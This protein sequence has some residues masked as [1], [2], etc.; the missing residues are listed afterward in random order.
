M[1]SV[2]VSD[3]DVKKLCRRLVRLKDLSHEEKSLLWA[4]FTIAAD[5][6]NPV[7]GLGHT[8]LVEAGDD[9]ELT[10]ELLGDASAFLNDF[11]GR[12]VPDRVAAAFAPGAMPLLADGTAPPVRDLKVTDGMSLKVR[13]PAT[14]KPSR[15]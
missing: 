4:V 3:A 11:D 13:A 5:V 7:D 6:L 14:Q 9:G 12:P 10:V 8:A 1:E 2:R 15:Y